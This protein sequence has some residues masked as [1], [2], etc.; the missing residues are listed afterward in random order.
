MR[1]P[2]SAHQRSTSHR[3]VYTVTARHLAGR[4]QT[5]A[6]ATATRRWA[7]CKR[8]LGQSGARQSHTAGDRTAVRASAGDMSAQGKGVARW[9]RYVAQAGTPFFSPR[10]ATDPKARSRSRTTVEPPIG[11][12]PDPAPL[13]PPVPHLMPTSAAGL[14]EPAPFSNFQSSRIE[15]CSTSDKAG[16]T[17]EQGPRDSRLKENAR[18]GRAPGLTAAGACGE[19]DLQD[20]HRGIGRARAHRSP[21]RRRQLRPGSLHGYPRASRPWPPGTLYGRRP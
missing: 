4:P 14:Q 15:T 2:S 1:A 11:Q 6:A 17:P 7:R 20:M 3:S 8:C 21:R 5:P 9:P 19:R 10:P 18:Q 16:W 13:P 12:R